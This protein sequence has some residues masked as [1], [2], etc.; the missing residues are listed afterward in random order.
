MNENINTK[1]TEMA[2]KNFMEKIKPM[3]SFKNIFLILLPILSI[4]P[5]TV[6]ENLSSNIYDFIDRMEIKNL[7]SLKSESKPYYISDIKKWLLELK[8]KEQLLNDIEKKQLEKYLSYYK[9]GDKSDI[10]PYEFEKDN[11]SINIQP[12]AGYS[13]DYLSG[14]KGHTRAGGIRLYTNYGKIFNSYFLFQDRGDFGD[15]VDFKKDLSHERGYAFVS[16][17]NGIEYSDIIAGVILDWDWA[18]IGLAKDYNRWGSGL[19]GQLILSDNVNSFPH[20]KFEYNPINWFRFQY[21]FGWLNSQVLD[22]SRYYHSQPGS[23]LDEIRYDFINKYIA[24]N[25][26]TFQPFDYLSFSV[27]NSFIYSGSTIRLESLIPFSFFKYLDRDVGKG[28]VAD[29]NGQMFFD[30]NFNY[31]NG[32]RLYGTFFI[33]VISIRKTFNNDFSENWFGY[34]VGSKIIDPIIKNLEFQFEY[35]KID[36][37]VYEHKDITTTYKHLNYNLG[38]WIGQNADLTNLRL[39]YSP[40]FNVNLAIDFQ[41]FRKGGLDD[42]YYPYEGRDE[43]KFSFLYSPLRKDL[44]YGFTVSY[45][46][47]PSLLI[48]CNV[49]FSKISDE[50]NDRTQDYLIGSKNFIKFGFNFGNTY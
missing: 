24:A 37:W 21:I 8:G 48:F 1:K 6:T 34:T 31:F 13:F 11:F 46:P 20:I 9:I 32:F 39:S 14:K 41:Y 25:L 33:D 44:S 30:M 45:E 27:G 15:F 10:L 42:I 36:P 2:V 26:F 4:N 50:D 35:T 17:P 38:H 12:I 18:K 22:S 29:G 3:F 7:I 16:A 49:K 23:K 5:Q 40:L 19:F 43:K 47:I 28:S